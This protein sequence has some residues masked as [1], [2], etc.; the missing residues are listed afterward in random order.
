MSTINTQ[1]NQSQINILIKIENE[2]GFR[3]PELEKGEYGFSAKS[4][5]ENTMPLLFK[6][7]FVSIQIGY[8]MAKL[9]YEYSHPNGGSNGYTIETFKV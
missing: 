8:N 7:I 6:E 3:F 9:S 4:K 5:V 1:L 2:Y